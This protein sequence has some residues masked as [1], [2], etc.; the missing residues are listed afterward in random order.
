MFQSNASKQ[1][2]RQ[3]QVVDQHRRVAEE[4]L[5]AIDAG[6][7]GVIDQLG[8]MV[9][10]GDI[11]VFD[12]PQ[13]LKFEVAGFMPVMDPRYPPGTVQMMLVC[14]LPVTCV[15]RQNVP[16]L[17]LVGRHGQL[18]QPVPKPEPPKEPEKQET[19]GEPAKVEGGSP[20]IHLTDTQ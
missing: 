19:T 15:I 3:R 20:L 13:L 17:F 1:A 6:V 16:G 2:E 7:S 10:T 14:Q 12:N 18:L 8:H 5:K 9:E 4:Q 11:V